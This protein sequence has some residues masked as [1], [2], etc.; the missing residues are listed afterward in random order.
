MRKLAVAFA[1]TSV[2]GLGCG[3]SDSGG[4]GGIEGPAAMPGKVSPAAAM[5]KTESAKAML[6][7]VNS[8]DGNTMTGSAFSFGGGPGDSSVAAALKLEPEQGLATSD[9][10]G[11]LEGNRLT[12]ERAISELQH[13]AAN[14]FA[15]TTGT[16]TCDMTGCVY[17]K[18]VLADGKGF[19]ENSTIDGSLKATPGTGNT[20]VVWNITM[21]GTGSSKDGGMSTI[22][23][24]FIGDLTVSPTLVS[25]TAGGTWSIKGTNA[26]TT[27]NLDYGA[28]YRFNDVALCKGTPIGGS[29]YAKVWSTAS[30]PGAT[31]AQLAMFNKAYEG[32]HTFTTSTCAP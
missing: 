1:M 12:V 21:T 18:C 20:H 2:L 7:A 10:A 24:N 11:T 32:T 16:A 6:T 8:G 4:G 15:C 13:R 17:T 30:A 23:L 5:A 22:N 31:S 25:G 3:G 26:G 9:L 28:R 29:I 14:S 19:G 27:V